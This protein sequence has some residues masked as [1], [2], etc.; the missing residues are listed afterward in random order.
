MKML[1]WI[2]MVFLLLCIGGVSLIILNDPL[3]EPCPEHAVILS[4]SGLGSV[5]FI[6]VILYH[7][8]TGTPTTDRFLHIKGGVQYELLTTPV[9]DP[10]RD[11]M[12]LVVIRPVG[13]QDTTIRRSLLYSIDD[14]GRKI[15]QKF[16]IL[17]NAD[18][19]IRFIPAE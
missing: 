16:V 13:E 18:N 4:V 8:G 19:K 5:L 9:P 15:P 17:R 6:V 11:G 7:L 14:P 1:F 12:I 10:D 2:L 3:N